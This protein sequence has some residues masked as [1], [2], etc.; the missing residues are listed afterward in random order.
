MDSNETVG[1]EQK[2]SGLTR[3]SFLQATA[4]GAV[5]S[6]ATGCAST[7]RREGPAVL[8]PGGSPERIRVGVI[9]CGGRGTG[10]AK[11]CVKAAPG[12]EIVALGDL[13]K[14]RLDDSRRSLTE[15]GMG[16]Q[17]TDER[18][19]VGFDAYKGVLACDVDLVILAA[20][21]GF[22]P[23]HLA[24]AVAAKKHVFMEKPV[25][26]DPGGVRTVMRASADAS[27]AGLAIVAGTQRRHDPAYIETI[28]RI[29]GGSIGEI[30]AAQCYWNQEGLWVKARQAE[31]SDMEWQC[32]NW[33]YFTWLSGDHIVE[34]HVHNIDVINWVLQAH[35]V[36]AMGLG[37]RQYRTGPEYGNIY[38]HFSV[39]FEYPGGVRVLS[40]CRQIDK[41]SVRVGER[42]VGTKGTANPNGQ[43]E[44]RRPWKYQPPD[45]PVNPYVQEHADLIASIRRGKPLN[46][47]QQI[48]ESTASAILGRMSA[49]TGREISWDWMMNSSK[50]DLTPARYEFGELQVDAVAIPGQTALV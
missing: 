12:V 36:K 45:P 3:R 7:G 24:A 9:G 32:R 39:E 15:A 50:L 16:S 40:T 35:P 33:L 46:E 37:G 5:A 2:L 43:I 47:G 34:Q 27:K 44:G 38:D 23:P 1:G 13:F 25:A 20:P 4:A 11:D 48:A 49:Y 10:A 6:L 26:V 8:P 18:C 41:T 19:F 31:W 21:P 28:K 22:R 14:D 42:V 17:I 29:H 30:V